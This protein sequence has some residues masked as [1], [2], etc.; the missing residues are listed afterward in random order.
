VDYSGYLQSEHWKL[1]RA[2]ALQRAGN[3]CQ[4]CG[5]RHNLNVHHNTYER[6]WHEEPEDMVV[7][8]SRCH[9]VFHDSLPKAPKGE[10]SY[11]QFWPPVRMDDG[12]I[13]QGPQAELIGYWKKEEVLV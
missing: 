7:F 4:A 6:L 8:C 11:R 5:S 9:Q 10:Y 2:E 12:R 3:K 1:I 13:L